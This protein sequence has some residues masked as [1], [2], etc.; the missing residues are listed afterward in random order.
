MR[1]ITLL[2]IVVL[3]SSC[4]KDETPI[5]KQ[6]RV[7][8]Q[9]QSIAMGSTYTEVVWF[10]L[11]TNTVVKERNKLEWDLTVELVNNEFIIRLN[12]SPF[13][14]AASTDQP[15]LSQDDDITNLPYKADEQSGFIDSLAIGKQMNDGTVF[16]LK[17]GY[18]NNGFE[19][20]P[21]FLKLITTS[22][23]AQ[24]QF[25]EPGTS[26]TFNIPLNIADNEVVAINLDTQSLFELVDPKWDICF[27]QYV[28]IFYEPD[29]T[30]YLVTGALQNVASGVLIKEIRD[31]SYADV[32]SEDAIF[33]AESAYQDVIG[34]DWKFFDLE[35]NLYTVD[36]SVTY[37]IQDESGRLFKLQFIDFYNDLGE[38]GYPLFKFEEL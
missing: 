29:Y 33:T 38:R 23:P 4:W 2:L 30:P 17:R 7:G 12:E 14:L 16:I 20:T 28:H 26:E 25:R 15:D 31:K 9:T 10:D 37:L 34:Y 35:A 24:L 19:R 11:A 21:Y 18:D 22:D 6:V 1:N 8:E 3:L 5:D 13:L 27:T 32:K 36:N